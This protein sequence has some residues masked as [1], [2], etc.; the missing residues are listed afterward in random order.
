MVPKKAIDQVFSPAPRVI[1]SGVRVNQVLSKFGPAPLGSTLP[2]GWREPPFAGTCAGGARGGAGGGDGA[3]TGARAAG[4]GGGGGAGGV[5][6]TAPAGGVSFVGVCARAEPAARVT[7]AR[8]ARIDFRGP[9]V[10]F[11]FICSGPPKPRSRRAG[12]SRLWVVVE[13]GNGSHISPKSASG[14]HV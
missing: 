14:L 9:E 10:G 2:S 6:S 11:S 8:A 1:F 5:A 4:A 12:Q 3:G 13:P 7:S